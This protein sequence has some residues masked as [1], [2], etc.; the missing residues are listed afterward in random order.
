MI[1]HLGNP[2]LVIVADHRGNAVD[3]GKRLSLCLR[4]AAGHDNAGQGIGALCPS[5]E[6]SRLKVGKRGY[7]AGIDDVGIGK[8]VKRN[9][10]MAGGLQLSG[11]RSRITLIYLAS[12][13]GQADFQY[14]FFHSLHP[15]D[16]SSQI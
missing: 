11:L 2:M 10:G 4:V 9:Q 8:G 3:G 15:A 7:R 13:C 12:Q 14:L 6:L 1:Q 5:D 16:L